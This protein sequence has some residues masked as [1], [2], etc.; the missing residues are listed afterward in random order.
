VVPD[1]GPEDVPATP[2]LNALSSIASAAT[3]VAAQCVEVAESMRI[4]REHLIAVVNLSTKYGN[5]ERNVASYSDG[6]MTV[7]DPLFGDDSGDGMR[8]EAV[9]DE[10]TN[11][12]ELYAA[13]R[14]AYRLFGG[15]A[16][17]DENSI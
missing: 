3:L 6:A 17:G 12:G 15:V 9:G 7:R 5:K 11:P 10:D 1:C 14:A 2:L 4:Q 13:I 16:P 8:I